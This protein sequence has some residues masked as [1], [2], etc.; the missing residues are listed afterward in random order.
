MRAAP[1]RVAKSSSRSGLSS[2][3]RA[4][5]RSEALAGFGGAFMSMYYSQGWNSGMVAGRGFIALA[6]Q[7]MGRA[8]LRFDLA[9]PE[10]EKAEPMAP[11]SDPARPPR[12]R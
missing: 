2:Q 9:L 10:E 4:S 7:A 12:L 1:V 6:A 11:G 8:G 3:A 5:A